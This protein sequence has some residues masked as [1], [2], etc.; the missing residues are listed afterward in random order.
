M[1]GVVALP[2]LAL[3]TLAIRLDS[4][5]PALFRQER[6]GR[7]GRTFHV[8]KFRT[9]LVDAEA[10]LEALLATDPAARLEWESSQKLARDPRVTRVGGFLRATSL[11]ELPQL[12]NVVL[13]EMSL[14]GPRPIVRAEI[15]RYAESYE[16]YRQVRPGITGYWQ[17]SGRSNTSY[18]QR[19]MLDTY[20]VRN[21]SI[22][23]DLVILLRTVTVVLQRQGAY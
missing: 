10:R 9:M 7:D 2:I 21:W 6:V 13:G 18:T 8:W 11:D 20:Y 17:V 5:G 12:W 14:V 16:Y 4:P 3:I 15:P 1:G 19:V 23:L 22:W